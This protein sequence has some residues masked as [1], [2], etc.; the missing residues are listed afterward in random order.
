[1]LAARMTVV[2]MATLLCDVTRSQQQQ[3]QQQQA[4]T[5]LRYRV[6][7]NC[8]V[9]T[10]VGTTVGDVVTDSRLRDELPRSVLPRLT[11][12][13]LTR[14]AAL[15]LDVGRHDGVLVTTGNVDREAVTSCRQRAS[16][17]VTVDVTV[18]PVTYFRIIKVTVKVTDVALWTHHQGCGRSGRCQRQRASVHR[19]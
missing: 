18:Q 14:P 19:R 6:T 2:V 7:E 10:T 17:D 5:A 3:Q 15:P 11:F 13:L 8:R 4:A 9:G 12:S 16:C 1:M